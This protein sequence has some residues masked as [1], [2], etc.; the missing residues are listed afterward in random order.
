MLSFVMFLTACIVAN[1]DD[2]PNSPV[3]AKRIKSELPST[4]EN[5]SQANRPK[6]IQFIKHVTPTHYTWLVYDRDKDAILV[7]TGGTWS[8]KDGKYE[9]S[10]DFA[11]DN[12]QQLRGKAFQ[13]TINLAGDKWDHKGVPDSEIKVDE[14]WTRMKQGDQ[15]KK[16]T[17]E[18]GAAA[19]GHLGSGREA[20]RPQGD[21]DDQVHHA[22]TLDLGGV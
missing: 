14:V 19:P 8:L 15:Q 2:N 10:I 17:G 21:E 18:P 22:D 20:R 1:G 13:F 9:E 11:S 16:N 3:D 4:W 5:V 7:V 6:E 12:A